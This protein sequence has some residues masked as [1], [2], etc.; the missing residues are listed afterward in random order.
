ML[1]ALFG[2][3]TN[4]RVCRFLMKL[5]NET[6]EMELKNGTVIQGTIIGTDGQTKVCPIVLRVFPSTVKLIARFCAPHVS[7]HYHCGGVVCDLP[8][9]VSYG[10]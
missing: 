6:V 9:R 4:P 5:T 10:G 7:M 3:C 1:Y 8:R 2:I